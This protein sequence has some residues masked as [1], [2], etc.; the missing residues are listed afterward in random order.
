V[1]VPT[2]ATEKRQA[3]MTVGVPSV[4]DVTV[5]A[6]CTKIPGVIPAVYTRV[7]REVQSASS[8]IMNV[9]TPLEHAKP[10]TAIKESKSVKKVQ[11]DTSVIVAV[12]VL[13][14]VNLSGCPLTKVPNP[15]TVKAFVVT[16]ATMVGMIGET[17]N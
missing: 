17:R 5:H 15:V 3:G 8:P 11:T 13:D 2:V 10:P 16:L 12:L 7:H 14:L 6:G 4:V 1:E 9:L